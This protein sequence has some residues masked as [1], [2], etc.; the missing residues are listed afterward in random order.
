MKNEKK[1]KTNLAP[2]PT[3]V[4]CKT[5]EG[6]QA[7]LDVNNYVNAHPESAAA[8]RNFVQMLQESATKIT[9]YDLADIPVR[10]AIVEQQVKDLLTKLQMSVDAD[11]GHHQDAIKISPPLHTDLVP[12][13]RPR[14]RS[15]HLTKQQ[16]VEL[17][18]MFEEDKSDDFIYRVFNLTPPGLAYQKRIYN[19]ES[20]RSKLDKMDNGSSLTRT[21]TIPEKLNDYLEDA[22][23]EP[24]AIQKHIKALESKNSPQ[25]KCDHLQAK[26][27]NTS[28]K[29][30]EPSYPSHMIQNEVDGN[31]HHSE[32]EKRKCELL[33]QPKRGLSWE[34]RIIMAYMLRNWQKNEEY[35]LGDI[36]KQFK[37]TKDSV[38]KYYLVRIKAAGI[39][40]SDKDIELADIVVAFSR[41][42]K[43]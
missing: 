20:E 11:N 26:P 17:Y 37:M 34:D 15:E 19:L 38:K 40:D 22:G 6:K 21:I 36:A 2:P 7:V 42:R 16:K 29:I 1:S 30:I 24:I 25:S 43:I 4:R 9:S 18:K 32:L 5:Q 10:I 33:S 39:L 8:I 12:H 13:G 14:K 35:T 23:M 28:S 41:A 27:D 31:E 3:S